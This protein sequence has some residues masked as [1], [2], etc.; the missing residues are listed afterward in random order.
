MVIINT[1][2]IKV[3]NH[4]NIDGQKDIIEETAIGSFYVKNGKIYI[5]YKTADETGFSSNTIIAE[6][7][8]VTVKRSGATKSSIVFDRRKRTKSRYRM[9][10]GTL[11]M[12]ITTEKI[13]N[14]LTE[15]G[16]QL[17]LVYTIM[18]QGQMIYND[19]RIFVG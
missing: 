14:A 11:D 3:M 4:Q 17:R 19:M 1:F 5:L 2:P 6:E 9:P 8:T 12:E 13:V 16:G 18:T 7:D 10:Y 15:D